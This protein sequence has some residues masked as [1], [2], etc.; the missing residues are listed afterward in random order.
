[1]LEISS[2]CILSPYVDNLLINY[3]TSLCGC[4]SIK[5]VKSN[6]MPEMS[7]IQLP[8]DILILV[9]VKAKSITII[10]VCVIADMAVCQ[11]NRFLFFFL[12]TKWDDKTIKLQ[13]RRGPWQFA[14]YKKLTHCRS[15]VQIFYTSLKYAVSKLSFSSLKPHHLFRIPPQDS[16]IFS[17]QSFETSPVPLEISLSLSAGNIEC[18]C[19]YTKYYDKDN[20]TLCLAL[21]TLSFILLSSFDGS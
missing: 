18:T 17:G 4:N 14:P 21:P 19:C 10:T 11:G 3:L 16:R 15:L 9:V 8:K 12:H 1:M 2:K 5:T 6:E 20:K 13:W 7:C